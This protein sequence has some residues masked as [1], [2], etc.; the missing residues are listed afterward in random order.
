M[1][2]YHPQSKPSAYP[3]LAPSVT[4][5]AVPAPS[6]RELWVRTTSH[7]VV[8]LGKC[9]LCIPQ[10]KIKDFCQLPFTREPLG[11]SDE[12]PLAK[13]GCLGTAEAGGYPGSAWVLLTYSL[14]TIH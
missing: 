8:L 10:S 9:L 2:K 13:G 14:F 12:A 11:C 4:A 5:I 3:P 6:R 1:S 7:W